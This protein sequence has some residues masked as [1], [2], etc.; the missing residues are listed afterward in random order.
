MSIKNYDAIVALGMMIDANPSQISKDAL[1]LKQ[2]IEDRIGSI[3]LQADT[4]KV[5]QAFQNLAKYATKLKKSNLN[6]TQVY[7]GIFD[8]FSD[9]N[10][11]IYEILDNLNNVEKKIKHL[12]S[13]KGYQLDMMSG[14]T[15]QQLDG[16]IERHE[17]I[18][19][20]L[21]KQNNLTKDQKIESD[22]L[23]NTLKEI[24]KYETRNFAKSSTFTKD[25]L[26]KKAIS[27]DVVKSLGKDIGVDTSNKAVYKDV[28]EY[29]KLLHIFKIL[30]EEKAEYSKEYKI[31]NKKDHLN[32]LHEEYK[33]YLEIEKVRKRLSSYDGFDSS[34]L[35]ST[36]PK[37]YAEPTQQSFLK[38]LNTYHQLAISNEKDIVEKSRAILDSYIEDAYNARNIAMQKTQSRVQEEFNKRKVS[39]KTEVVGDEGLSR[40]TGQV[41]EIGEQT[42]K[43]TG[44][45]NELNNALQKVSSEDSGLDFWQKSA[46]NLK[47]EF[48]DLVK[49]A[50]S[51][52]DSL[53]NLNNILNQKN[54][55]TWNTALKQ[56][57]VGFYNQ[58][59]ALNNAGVSNIK[60]TEEMVNV[61]RGLFQRDF[62]KNIVSN[63]PKMV[64]SQIEEIEKLKVAQ[65]E[66]GQETE[67]TEGKFRDAATVSSSKFEELLAI[68]KQLVSVFGTFDGSNLF[69]GLNIDELKT[70]FTLIATNF[71]DELS[72]SIGDFREELDKTGK[73][74][75]SNLF[76]SL[77]E[78]FVE[79]V[80]QFQKSLDN[81][82]FTGAQIGEI[83]KL[84]RQWNEAS[85]VIVSNGN[86]DL[87]RAALINQSTGRISNS[88]LYDKEGSFAGKMLNDLNKLESGVSGKIGE[89]YDTWLHS[90]PFEKAMDNLRTIG[91]N[92]GFSANDLSLFKNKYLSQGVT[93]MMVASN[94]KYASI[95]WNGIS[96]KLIDEVISLFKQS[97][98]FKDGK[99]LGKLATENGVYN[100]DKQSELLNNQIIQSMTKVGISDAA[101]RFKTGNIS[102][103]NADL[104]KMQMEET[105]AIQKSEELLGVLKNISSLLDDFGKSTTFKFDG[106]DKLI[107]DLQ[108]VKSL[109]STIS[110]S[111]KTGISITPST[112]SNI[113]SNNIPSTTENASKIAK[114]SNDAI[115]KINETKDSI[116]KS[117][118]SEKQSLD[119][120]FEAVIDVE[121]AVLL[122]NNAFKEEAQIVE[123]SVNSE[124]GDLNKLK[125]TLLEVTE[126][127][128]K[129][130]ESM[131][132][133]SA[134]PGTGTSSNNGSGYQSD[135]KTDPASTKHNREL[136]AEYKNLIRKAKEYYALKE[137]ASIDGLVGKEV[138]DL[139]E[140]EI[141]WSN[142]L[143]KVDKYA[144][145]TNGSLG[146]VIDAKKIQEQFISSQGSMY[147]NFNKSYITNIKKTVSG[148]KTGNFTDSYI[149][150]LKLVDT[151]LNK[152]ELKL[153]IDL[154]NDKEIAEVQ[155]LKD[156]I[157][158]IIDASDSKKNKLA[159]STD[160][161]R[162]E[163]DI[164]ETLQRNS[165]MLPHLRNEFKALGNE[166]AS[167]KG[168]IPVEKLDE[169]YASFQ[170]LRI[171][172]ER[173]G[174]VGKSFF[175]KVSDK[176]VYGWAQIAARYLSFYDF[177]RYARK[178]YENVKTY[179]TALT[180]MRKV[181]E[182]TISTLKEFQKES[183]A[184]A[185]AVGTTAS[186]LQKS[187][188]DWMRLGEVLEE[189]KESAEVSNILLNVSEFDNIDAATESL[190]AM[191][192]AY[193]DLEKIEIVDK[194]NE[195]GNNYAISTDGLATALQ[196]SASALVTAGN[197]IDEAIALATAGN[198][199]TQDPNKVGTGLR[200]ISLR[201]TGTEA[202][203]E[204]LEE[205]GEDTS[206]F[207]VRTKAKS[208]QAIKDFTR[209]ASNSFQGFDILDENG[210]FKSTYEIMLG[211][212][213]I[214]QEI[215][216][217]DKKY[218]SNM[219]NGLLE[220]LA[221]KNRSN[222][223]ASI[224]QNPEILKASYESSQ[225]AEGSAQDELQKY[226]ESLEG[227]VSRFKNAADQLINDLVSSDLLKWI[228]DFATNVVKATDA[229]VKFATPLG[230]V[231]GLG[232]GIAGAKGLGL[233]NYVTYHS[234]RV[235]F[236][237]IA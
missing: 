113:N 109:L 135:K 62:S 105:E 162:L 79:I 235:P 99:F 89:L 59:L 224:L 18:I 166:L 230:T 74:D 64:T 9:P 209:V 227:H 143:E 11:S 161:F 121:D 110:S 50:V 118:T 176:I 27:D 212:S 88:Y 22:R 32:V 48:G 129:K 63:V 208:Q 36:L 194:L 13:L 215:V 119:K 108:E 87:E 1:K 60:I 131:K 91:S 112:I 124:I 104:S 90:H 199:V 23:L 21:Q 175:A 8:S 203:K 97:D 132:S 221:G 86:K 169:F 219:K 58:L 76:S 182:E 213:E 138:D 153:P 6:L 181:S 130:N 25:G 100:F 149:E 148:L 61:Y 189:A 186:Q 82:K 20:A 92:I 95:D 133:T 51:A 204:E 37:N 41:Q 68:L 172:M 15:P 2:K 152:I 47:D 116:A 205:L 144:V 154:T 160:A 81:V 127:A 234:L 54:N 75:Y 39:I 146:S 106:L 45:V 117:A 185:D 111:L 126:Q 98:I 150:E 200:T 170:K 125:D 134:L 178:I 232:A 34:K 225:N 19:S 57:F 173:S 43:V 85:N 233:T 70:E 187:T 10:K 49:Y 33:I 78:T 77:R 137:R 35:A 157:A 197:D 171:E 103:L 151:Y 94:G 26:Y 123:N 228:I 66:L 12:A 56:D 30:N 193:K 83:R 206:D 229:L 226:L 42:D 165:G 190:V 72:N 207:I 237:K 183:Y 164:F 195:V 156:L 231:L 141:A 145:K 84:L 38:V 196:S 192:S 53:A 214:Y 142:A 216:E 201:I 44:E 168:K 223:A 180:E 102:E 139:K 218:G 107:T 202:A 7:D 211:I 29:S 167:Y 191:S 52:E 174:K 46:E 55:G 4:D 158:T 101:S 73:A 69:K 16:V 128:D 80:K 188:A 3:E 67:K 14:F 31:S 236:Y 93:N 24:D 184:T 210:N 217:T 179:D 5:T 155:R 140:L 71:G 136:I 163:A 198:A 28:Q 122:K 114:Q 115:K 147:E 220:T 177:I 222:I 17:H 159:N 65:K 120:L 96:E 40:V